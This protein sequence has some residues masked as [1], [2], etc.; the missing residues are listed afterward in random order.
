VTKP[1]ILEELRRSKAAK[2]L[3]EPL[4][5]T[6][7]VVKGGAIQKVAEAMTE[8]GLLLEDRAERST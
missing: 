7:V 8:M 3:G 4:G 2:Y 1:K 5:P 6:S